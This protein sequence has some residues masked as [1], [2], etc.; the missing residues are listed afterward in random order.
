MHNGPIYLD[1]AFWVGVGLLIFLAVIIWKRVPAALAK[2]LDNRSAAIANELAE[3]KRLRTEAE[4]LLSSYKTKAAEAEKEAAD[5][6]AA[7]RNEA[8]QLEKESKVQ[9]EALI[10]RRT[11]MAEGKIR[12]AETTAL[13]EVKSAAAEA[14]VAAA[15]SLLGSRMDGA[16]ASTMTDAA[17][18]DLRARLN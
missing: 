9:L 13:A 14:A 5:I 12:Q 18:R 8:S 1:P 4:N 7:A 11:K 2:Q 6:L 15:A 17:I 16:K 3:A 10:A